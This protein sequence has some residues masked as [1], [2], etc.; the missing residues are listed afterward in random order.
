MESNNINQNK[1]TKA[2]KAQEEEEIDIKKIFYLLLRQWHWFLLFGIL[3]FGGGYIYSRLTKQLYTSSASILVP[4]KSTGIDMKNLFEGALDQNNT[5]ILNQ[6]QIIKSYYTINQTLMNLA[7]RTDWYKKDLFIWNG[8]YKKEPFEVT[9]ATNFNNLTG[10]PIYISAHSDDTYEISVDGVTEINGAKVAVKFE[11]N[12]TFGRT[13]MNKYFNFILKKKENNIDDASGSYY[14]VFN[15]LANQTLNYRKRLNVVQTDKGSDIIECSIDGEQPA[16]EVEF[17]NE[18]INKYITGKM[19]LQNAAQSRSLKFINAQLTGITDSLNSAGTKFSEFRSKNKIID[20]GAE[21]KLVMDNLKEIETDKAKSQMQ[22]DYFKDLLK[23][24]NNT[25]DLKELVAPSVVGIEDVSLNALVLKL[26]ELYNRRQILAFTAK[27]NTPSLV[28][29]DKELKQAR[30]QLNENLRNL[31]D[32]ATRNINSQNERQQSISSELNKLPEKEQQMINIQRQF[33]LTNEIY[34]FLL[35]KRAETNIALASSIPDVQIIDNALLETVTPKGL[36]RSVI[37]IMAVMLGLILPLGFIL[38]GN[39]F[40]SRIR[41]QEDIENNTDLPILGNIMHA[42]VQSDLCVS[43]NPKSNI[44]ESFRELRTNLEFMISGKKGKVIGL[45]ST[46]PGEGKSFNA[47]NLASI[48]AMNNDKVIIIGAD[49]R[50]PKL[51]KIFGID[52]KKGLSTYLIGHDPLEE[53]IFPTIIDNLW[54]IPSGPVPPNPAE[55][56]NKQ[57]TRDLIEILKTKYDYIIFDNAPVALVTDGIIVSRLCDL[58]IFILRYN[59]S[60][61]HQV[62]MINQLADKNKVKN[63]GLIVNDIKIN[64][65]GYSYYRYYEYEAYQSRYYT[66]EDQG[67]SKKG[68]RRTKTKS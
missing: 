23:Y 65:F 35:Q 29:L 15:D 1:S 13:F 38:L 5:K 43:E 32:N 37:M 25:S 10:I 68:N 27:E 45:H 56:L 16:K 52:N 11:Q 67:L 30:T 40:D 49:L 39:F 2:A 26:G 59:V 4:E 53:I 8:I 66:A 55:I 9:E 33:D 36:S 7:W 51:H 47:T 42:P 20:L 17:L 24:L 34:T 19:E 54:V 12:G 28:M 6:I 63:I 14:F 3:G 22:L 48:L 41:T 31:I 64:S 61:R 60:K 21:G 46:N 18:L 50:K 62:E 44:A 57:V 58:N